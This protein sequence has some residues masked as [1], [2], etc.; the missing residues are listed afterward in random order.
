M[1]AK[2]GEKKDPKRCTAATGGGAIAGALTGVLGAGAVAVAAGAT[3]L[4]GGL[5]AIGAGIVGGLAGGLLGYGTADACST[6][7]ERDD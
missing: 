1:M 6:K 2:N 3:F 7:E 4:T 5:F